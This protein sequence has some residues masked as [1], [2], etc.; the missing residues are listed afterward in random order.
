[1]FLSLSAASLSDRGPPL[2]CS[3]DPRDSDVSL[4]SA[5]RSTGQELAVSPAPGSPL[6]RDGSYRTLRDLHGSAVLHR[7]H[8]R[9]AQL[10]PASQRGL[11]PPLLLHGGRPA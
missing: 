6:H 11:R 4:P 2:G 8:P 1:D 9:G 3:G 10:L 5:V 7:R